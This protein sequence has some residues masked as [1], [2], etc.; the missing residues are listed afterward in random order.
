MELGALQRLMV[1]CGAVRAFKAWRAHGETGQVRPEH[2]LSYVW[3]SRMA[4]AIHEAAGLWSAGAEMRSSFGS[5]FA[6]QGSMEE[7]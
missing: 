7:A 6:L 1:A 4:S 3:H 5:V 2:G